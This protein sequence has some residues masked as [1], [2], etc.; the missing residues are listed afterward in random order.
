M[1]INRLGLVVIAIAGIYAFAPAQVT[2]VGR[3]HRV[4]TDSANRT[5]L[6]LVQ[7]DLMKAIEAM[8]VALPI[9]DG[10]RVKSVGTAH[11]GLVYLNHAL[12]GARAP[13]VRKPEIFD[14]TRSKAAHVRYSKTQIALSQ[15]QMQAGSQYLSKAATDLQNAVNG[16]YGPYGVKLRDFIQKSLTDSN[17]AI[18]LL[19]AGK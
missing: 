19:P 15:S 18:A 14:T 11:R 10:Y 3:H 5:G 13:E 1:K 16:N 2:I 17:T 4:Q 6:F 12:M 8:K 9:Y 7:Q